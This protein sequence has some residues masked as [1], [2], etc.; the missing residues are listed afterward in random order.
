MFLICKIVRNGRMV[1]TDKE[2]TFQCFRR[3]FGAAVLDISDVLTGR[4]KQLDAE[5][6]M[7][8]LVSENEE[9][10]HELPLKIMSNAGVCTRVCLYDEYS[11]K[12]C[13]LPGIQVSLHC[14]RS[15]GCPAHVPR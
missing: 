3:P 14:T 11:R 2:K 15:R 1:S 13:A 6:M 10:W 9:E 12:F 8:I 7:P 5:F 4:N